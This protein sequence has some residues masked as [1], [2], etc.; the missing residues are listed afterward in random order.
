M[1]LHV[2]LNLSR[3]MLDIIEEVFHNEEDLEVLVLEE[4][5]T[6]VGLQTGE[7]IANYVEN[8]GI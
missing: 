3:I 6:V 8:Q 4:T 5:K 1:W 2:S 7:F